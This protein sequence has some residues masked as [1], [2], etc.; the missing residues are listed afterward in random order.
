MAIGNRFET[1]AGVIER[2]ALNSLGDWSLP[3]L[4]AS[5][6]GLVSM[7]PYLYAY[8]AHSPGTGQVFMGFFFL[9]DDANTYLA[10]MR[11]GWEGSWLWTNRYSTEPGPGAYF[12]LFWLFLGHVAAAAKLS[13]IATFHL[14]RLL[15]ALALMAAGWAFIGQFVPRPDARRFAIWFMA[16]G[17][18]L[19]VV[20]W[21]LNK[22]VVFGQPT[23]AL[24]WRMPELSAFYSILALP[25][26]VWVAAFQAIGVVLT[27]KA[28]ETGKLRLG[29]LAGLAW[30]A[31]STIH[32]QMIVLMAGA[33]AIA[34]AYRRASLRGNLAVILAFAICAPYVGYSYYESAYSPEVLRWSAQW[35]NNLPPD[36]VSLLAALAPQLLLASLALPGMWRRRSRGDVF[37]VA[38]LV[39]LAAI[40]WL[41]NP[42]GNLR[43]RF[44]D[45]IYLPLVVMA[46]LGLYEQVI[47]RV[48]S[49]RLRRLV[50]FG[51]VAFSAVPSIFLLLAPTLVQSSPQYSVSRAE[52]SALGW[53]AT[54]P[55]GAVLSSGRMGLFV[56][57]YTP[58]AVYVGQY[59]ETYNFFDKTREAHSVLT[60]EE[61]GGAFARSHGIRYVLWSDEFG[62]GSEPVGLGDPVYISR[63]PGG[64]EARVYKLY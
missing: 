22:P 60:G 3:L 44:F 54:Q 32:A 49:A 10:K 63:S 56:P 23:D 42:A 4:L 20:I 28:A 13:L 59:S 38:W 53:L 21:T 24:D 61:D 43:R 51:Y 15:G 25:H 19:G 29:L 47:A 7:L 6:L 41:P 55:P 34:L 48:R 37:L 14:A 36:G 12:F 50:P 18:G 8:Q 30:L 33:L 26:F 35:R 5:V 52:Y 62:M 39:L 31:E 1:V 46:A 40:L 45:G 16:F 9:G 27:L 11:E 58:D 64:H 2:R 57:A 17:L